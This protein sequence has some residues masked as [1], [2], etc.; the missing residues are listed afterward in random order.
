MDGTRRD[1]SS[2]AYFRLT[3]RRDRALQLLLGEDDAGREHRQHGDHDG[4][5]QCAEIH[6]MAG[7]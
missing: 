2:V 5:E 7:L 6:R 3:A 1:W 4:G